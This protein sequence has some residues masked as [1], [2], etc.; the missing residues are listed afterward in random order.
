MFKKIALTAIALAIS[1]PA[2]AMTSD[3]L[4]RSVG[5][6]PG[7]YTQAQLGELSTATE[8]N[9]FN[10]LINFFDSQKEAG[11]TRTDLSGNWVAPPMQSRGSDR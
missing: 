2:F 11:V 4:A 7:V 5:V 8:A 1:A 9:D 6:E 3:Q 10:R